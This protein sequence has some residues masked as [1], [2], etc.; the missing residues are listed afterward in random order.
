MKKLLL[1]T[2][3]LPLLRLAAQQDLRQSP[4]HLV[5]DP[6]DPAHY[7]GVTVA[8]GML[9]LVTS[10][11]P[12]KMKDIVLNGAF[13]TYGRGRVSNIL[14]GFNFANMDLD[15]QPAGQPERRQR[16]SATNVSGMRQRLDMKQAIFTSTFEHQGLVTVSY[17]ATAL[18]HLPFT[19]M[20]TLEVTALQD[21]EIY[22]AAV[23]RAPEILREVSNFY[24]VIDRPHAK[25]P[26]MTSTAATPTGKHT[27]AA[28]VSFVFGDHNLHMP[29]LIHEEWDYDMH[30][31]RFYK[32][33]KAGERFSFDIVASEVS[34][35]HYADPLN[36]AERLT[37]YAA[38]EGRERLMAR[39]TAAWAELWK[40]DIILEGDLE[41]QRAIRSSLY[42]LYAF[43][44]EGTAYS[45]SPMGLSG[46]G[47]NGHVFWDTEFWMY[48]PLLVMQPGIARSLLEY[49]YERLEAARQNAF[50]H[51]YQGAMFP[52]E[53]DDAGQEA[54]PVWALT[55]PFEHHITGCVGVAAWNYY[56]LTRDTAWLRT[57][58]YPILREVAAFWVSRVEPDAQGVC[59]INNVVGADE[60][61]ENVDDNAFTN[62]VAIA[63]LRHAVTAARVLGQT[64]PARWTE[65]ANAIP[66]LTFPDGTTREYR[67]Y[68][69]TTIKQADAN[70]LTFPLK[71]ITDPAAVRRDLAFYEPRLSPGGPAMGSALLAVIYQRL[72]EPEKARELFYKG[73]RPNQ[74]P[75]FGV[76]AECPGC[77]NPYFATGAGGM[78]QAILFGFGGLDLTD[79]GLVQLKSNLPKSW[80][81]LT[82]TGVGID[83]RTVVIK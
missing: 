78:L 46:L 32:R 9:G 37:I 53:S 22:P 71:L 10:P 5:A 51:G 47:Y 36:E 82:L 8:N 79:Q 45:L 11:E 18:R 49:R 56:Q 28:S 25:V 17:S 69:D 29:E 38:L 13:D 20:I 62:G 52:W 76:L 34:S 24:S 19:S 21:V 26:L 63:S 3:F 31:T 27:L 77:A 54:T 4:W 35:A 44:R 15:V 1:L 70:L 41:A 74:I 50:S 42:H 83:E 55:G 6:V 14:R 33:L 60:W 67:G 7:A 59:H 48:P 43:A 80:K 64:P 58:G 30:L 81:S 72:S 75:P 68:Q 66:I 39:H 12:L 65:V 23:L 2:L 16:I 61:A 40:S 57:R 73:Y